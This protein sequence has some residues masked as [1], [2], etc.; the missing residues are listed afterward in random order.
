MIVFDMKHTTQTFID[1]LGGY[2]AVAGKLG[3]K[4]RTVHNWTRFP[5]FPLAQYH[6]LHRLAAE[7][8]VSAPP[9]DLFPFKSLPGNP[10]Y[11]N[12]LDR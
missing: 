4:P 1:A 5:A 10:V 3:Q 7:A 8:G 11:Q 2:R 9:D 12:S 6:N